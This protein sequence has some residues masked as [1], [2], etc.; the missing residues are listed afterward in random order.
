MSTE[1]DLHQ[2]N[3]S[4][5]LDNLDGKM[6]YCQLIAESDIVPPAFRGRPANVMIAIETA[7]QLGDAP[8]TV[9][10]EMAI[11]SG[12]PSLSAKYIRSL[13]RRAGHRLRETYRD[14]VAT[15]VIVRA[16]DPEFEHVATWDEKKAKQHDL[17]GKGHWRKNP[18]L[19]L[20]N[21]ALTECAREACFEA[22]AGIGYTPDEIQDF[23]K[24]EP[25][26]PRVTVQQVD[27]SR[28][29][30]A[31]T[32]ANV[33]ASTMAAI[34]SDV[35]GRHIDSG[36]EL[37]QA[38]ADAVAESLEE[39]LRRAKNDH[40]AGGGVDTETGEVTPEAEVQE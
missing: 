29:R 8:F 35:L 37:S 34:A 28:L 12:K 19:M 6:Q 24:P 40:P 36:A 4:G 33:D 16:D 31:M 21:R 3:P 32:A 23:A 7:G 22:M 30:D 26:T 1:L 11:I 10:Q 9:M 13:V 20:K 25:A 39:D 2:P 38:D 17:W 14:G 27:F 5:Y 15:C 18:E